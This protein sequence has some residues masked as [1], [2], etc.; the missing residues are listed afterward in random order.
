MNQEKEK[1]RRL[2]FGVSD[3]GATRANNDEELG[4]ST[5]TLVR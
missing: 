4:S 2:G 1:E 3:W 5:E